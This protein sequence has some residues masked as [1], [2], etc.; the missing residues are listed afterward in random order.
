MPSCDDS[1]VLASMLKR[2]F[3][4]F[5]LEGKVA[6]QG[7]VLIGPTSLERFILEGKKL[8]KFSIYLESLKGD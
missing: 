6:V 8:A 5:H 2:L 1:W 3:P 7:G 4:T